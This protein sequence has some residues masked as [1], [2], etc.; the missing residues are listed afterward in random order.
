MKPPSPAEKA[1]V[2]KLL[3]TSKALSDQV[4]P[5]EVGE[6]I[7]LLRTRLRM[8]Q[9]I[10]ARRAGVPQSYVANVETGHIT[11][12]LKSL[13]KLLTALECDLALY[14]IPRAS[15]DDVVEKKAHS[16]ALKNLYHKSNEVPSSSKSFDALVAEEKERLLSSGSAHIWDE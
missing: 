1:F 11:P 6:I 13:R 7:K 2:D 15:L 8:T 10:L 5:I 4:G 3:E 14:P 9:A 12:T 16:T